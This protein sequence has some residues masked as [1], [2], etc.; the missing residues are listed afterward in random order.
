MGGKGLLGDDVGACDEAANHH[1]EGE[2]DAEPDDG[3]SAETGE[4]ID[5][6]GHGLTSPV[7]SRVL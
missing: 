7:Y 4:Q 6:Y 1:A 2:L 3:P 5:C